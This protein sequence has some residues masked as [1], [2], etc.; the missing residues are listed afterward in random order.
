MVTQINVLAKAG[1]LVNKVPLVYYVEDN[2]TASAKTK[3][4]FVIK[5][6]NDSVYKSASEELFEGI[7]HFGSRERL[8]DQSQEE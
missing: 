2:R 4:R 1:K 8:Y 3:K 5:L 6:G 7:G